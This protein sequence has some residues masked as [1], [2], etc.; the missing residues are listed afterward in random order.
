MMKSVLFGLASLATAVI[1][2]PTA[3]AQ[4]SGTRSLNMAMADTD[5]RDGG[6]ISWGYVSYSQCYSARL[7]EYDIDTHGDGDAAGSGKCY[8]DNKGNRKCIIPIGGPF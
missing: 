5:C 7:S 2:I 1:G 3:E 8:T 6:Y 4:T